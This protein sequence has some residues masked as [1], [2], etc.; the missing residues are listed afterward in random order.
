MVSVAQDQARNIEIVNS[1]SAS[2]AEIRTVSLVTH[3]KVMVEKD[4]IEAAIRHQADP[5]GRYSRSLIDTAGLVQN[6]RKRHRDAIKENLRERNAMKVERK[7]L[8]HKSDDEKDNLRHEI[9]RLKNEIQSSDDQY[10]ESRNDFDA[11]QLRYNDLLAD[12]KAGD[13]RITK[14]EKQAKTM[15]QT[16]E[17]VTNGSVEALKLADR[18]MKYRITCIEKKHQEEL[19][20]LRGWNVTIQDRLKIARRLQPV[21]IFHRSQVGTVSE[22]HRKLVNMKK[23]KK[24][25]LSAKEDEIKDLGSK[26]HHHEREIRDLKVAA[27]AGGEDLKENGRLLHDT[28]KA[29]RKADG[30]IETHQSEVRRL[31]QW[32]KA[33]ENGYRAK[34]R[35]ITSLKIEMNN[36]RASQRN[37]L[38][39]AQAEEEKLQTIIVCLRQFN[40]K[41]SE[42]LEASENGSLRVSQLNNNGTLLGG[43]AASLVKAL[44][45]ANARADTLQI[46]VNAL[47]AQNGVLQ[48]QLGNTVYTFDAEVQ[49]QLERSKSETKK[50]GEATGKVQIL[51]VE[52]EEQFA[53]RTRQL[54]LGFDK[55]FADLRA[56]R[57]QWLLQKQGLEAEFHRQLVAADLRR[58]IERKGREDRYLA[59]WR[60][61]EEALH[62]KE[63][64]LQTREDGLAVQL[65]NLQSSSQTIV[66]MKTR[67]EKAEAE[68][69]QLQTAAANNEAHRNWSEQNHH[70][71]M[72]SQRRD[73]Q[74]HLDLLNEETGKMAEGSR[75]KEL[76]GELQDANSCMTSFR[77]S[78]EN[79]AI[80]GEALIQSLYGAEFYDSDVRLLQ[81]Q[82]RPVL[83]AQL[84][85]AKRVLE[86]LRSLL[87]ETSNVEKEKAISMIEAPRGDE[88]A[89]QPADDILGQ[90]NEPQQLTGQSSPRKRPGVPLG[91]PTYG[92]HE[93]T[94]VY[95]DWGVQE[96]STGAKISTAEEI[97]N[98]RRFQPKSRRT[99]MSAKPVLPE[100]I[101]PAI[102]DQ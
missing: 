89:A 91:A 28:R 82:G 54:E 98:R 94:T 84:E 47:Q 34:I 44:K 6:I 96:V 79:P 101:D 76:Y 35:D 49:E 37:E 15:R 92:D 83:L 26:I 57:D 70:S 73:G 8:Q 42:E 69:Q 36:L 65:R 99:R 18:R 50:L 53:N 9:R 58:D 25:E 12:K 75:L 19:N 16:C 74:R 46:S 20:E 97:S 59:I 95:D 5:E 45:A 78:I 88:E 67:A 64:A 10:Q 40:E 1:A 51:K 90:P 63:D 23:E 93:E 85:A 38:I 24:E 68:V 71:Q 30:K 81:N 22:M 11:L 62:R 100:R 33:W 32:G 43:E 52:L 61:R 48:R 31:N 80:N 72:M 3:K 29:L 4:A 56:L 60:E 21:L 7:D 2:T 13:D 27:K 86:R 77:W 41:M 87:A 39:T 66:E 55:G 17:T 14:L 102:G